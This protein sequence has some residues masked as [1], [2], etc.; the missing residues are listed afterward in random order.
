M[1]SSWEKDGGVV[2]AGDARSRCRPA[3]AL[4]CVQPD[5]VMVAVRRD[6]RRLSAVLLGDLEAQDAAVEAQ[7]VRFW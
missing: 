5:V 1:P 7:R 4:L 2:E 3:P 6:E